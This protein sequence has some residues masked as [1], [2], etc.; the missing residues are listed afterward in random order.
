MKIVKP[1]LRMNIWLETG[2]GQALG[3]GRA[4]L[5]QMIKEQGSLNRAAAKLGM[6]YRAAWGKLKK[7]EQAI[8]QKL[9]YK[10]GGRRKGYKLTDLA[11]QLL[12][13]YNAWC[14]EIEEYALEKASR[15]FP[16]PITRYSE[17][18]DP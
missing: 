14:A 3:R 5:L 18:D 12:E 4:Q 16:W 2:D 6:S 9:V 17:K 13:N 1:T 7:T 15:R 8:G 10:E 11:E